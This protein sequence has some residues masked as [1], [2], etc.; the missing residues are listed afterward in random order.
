[1]KSVDVLV[2]VRNEEKTIPVFIN[3]FNTLIPD[4]IK[5]NIIFLEDGSSDG[6]VKLLQDLS[7]KMNNVNFISL[8]NKF[9]QYAALTYGLSLSKAD[10]V[11]TMDVDGGHPV[12][13]AVE[14]IKAFLQGNNL[15][16][17]H[18]IVYKRKKFYRTIMS[19]AYN[20]FFYIIV[21]VNFFK[22]NVMFRLMDK[23]TKDKFLSNKNWWHI[24]KTNFKSKDG[25]KTSYIE[26]EAPERE[27]GESKYNFFRLFKLSYKSF[28]SLLSVYRLII[29]NIVLVVLLVLTAKC[30]SVILSILVLLIL[31]TINLS[32]FLIVKHYPIPE[33]KIISTSLP[34]IRN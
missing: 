31:L 12:E 10:A 11:I 3:E 29:I 17:G 32:Y 8:D 33:L 26:Y 5:L 6:T 7:R 9:G 30:I 14:M 19:Y 1:M 24:F 2:A 23:S 27:L 34:E 28:F 25:I 15:V 13:T 21:G 4:D 16:Q 22:Q 20:L 18:R